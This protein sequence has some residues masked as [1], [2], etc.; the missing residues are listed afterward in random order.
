MRRDT[1]VMESLGVCDYRAYTNMETSKTNTFVI[2]A[3]EFLR[4]GCELG[5]DNS[6]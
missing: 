1:S 6:V 5:R 4:R 2:D 3:V